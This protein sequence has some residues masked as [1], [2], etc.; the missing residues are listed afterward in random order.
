MNRTDGVPNETIA[1]MT[2]RGEACRLQAEDAWRDGRLE[3]AVALFR[4]AIACLPDDG[5]L[6]RRLANA[7]KA[8]ERPEEARA[9]YRVAIALEPACADLL[10]Q[11]GNLLREQ[12]M[13][14]AAL[15]AYRH[16]LAVRL[17]IAALV[18]FRLALIAADDDDDAILSTCR[19]V[20]AIE[21][22]RMAGWRDLADCLCRIEQLGAARAAY[23]RQERLCP[24]QAMVSHNIAVLDSILGLMAKGKGIS[25]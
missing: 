4:Q 20:L 3:D 6:R 25:S 14:A 19:A 24:G 16:A 10:R 9:S 1:P 8:A 11:S 7:W 23:R 2:R 12:G 17:D 13:V 18:Q 21:P 15:A 5:A 22:D